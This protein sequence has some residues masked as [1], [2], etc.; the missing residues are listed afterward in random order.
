MF[1]FLNTMNLLL[2]QT[3]EQKQMTVLYVSLFALLCFM[4]ILDAGAL[5][6][7]GGPKV[8]KKIFIAFLFIAIVALIILY[9]VW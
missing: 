1:N 3:K 8:W 7:I 4:L 6:K 2:A 5:K 9:F